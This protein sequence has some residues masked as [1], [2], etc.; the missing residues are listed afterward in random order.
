MG[1]LAGFSVMLVAPTGQLA[2]ESD[3][4][5]YVAEALG[6][7]TSSAYNHAGL[8]TYRVVE[9]DSTDVTATGTG[10]WSPAMNAARVARLVMIVG[11][12][13]RTTAGQASEAT[14]AATTA[15]NPLTIS[16]VRTEWKCSQRSRTDD[17]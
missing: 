13:W 14:T 11:S 3:S 12:P 10:G 17:Q 6:R 8:S 5:G 15:K 1:R 7:M 2:V 9:V 16:T 4:D